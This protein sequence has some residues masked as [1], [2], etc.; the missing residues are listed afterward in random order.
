ME[1]Y[2]IRHTA[3]DVPQGMCYGRT[4][5]LPASSFEDEVEI[6]KTKLP[7]SF[8]LVVSSPAKRTVLLSNS[9]IETKYETNEGI[10]ELD[11]GDWE[12]MQ[13][14]D[15]PRD[16]CREWLDDFV[17]LSPP[18]GETFR[19]MEQRVMKVWDLIINSN[20]SRIL[21]VAHGGA[22]RAIICN[23]LGLPLIKAFNLNIDYGGISLHCIPSQSP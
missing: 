4:D 21:V 12:G 3:V 22:I 13:W 14:S 15:M 9:L 6:I 1:I 19:E 20:H 18:G 8:D 23:I 17:N 5:V 7:S 2:L 10:W 16:K 11:Y